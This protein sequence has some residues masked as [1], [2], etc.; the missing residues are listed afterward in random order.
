VITPF[1]EVFVGSRNRWI[2]P[3]KETDNYGFA[4]WVL[5]RKEEF[6]KALGPGRYFGEWYGKGIARGYGLD[7]RK[8]AFFN[9]S[10]PNIPE[11]CEK[12]PVL[13]QGMMEEMPLDLILEDLKAG[14]SKVNPEFKRPE[15]IMIY[16]EP[17]GMYYKKTYKGDQ[18]GKERSG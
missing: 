13:W 18:Y 5:E 3:G 10:L 16:H 17:S 12:V 14:G 6:M 8:F 1:G 9:V 4:K 7:E 15:G 2:N 11:F